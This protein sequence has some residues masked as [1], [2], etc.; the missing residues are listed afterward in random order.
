MQKGRPQESKCHVVI[1][2][3][4]SPLRRPQFSAANDLSVGIGSS[5]LEHLIFDRAVVCSSGQRLD[6]VKHENLAMDTDT[7]SQ[8]VDKKQYA[9][10]ALAFTLLRA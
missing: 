4:L 3:V 7:E 10:D 1:V 2:V 8:A 9:L 6:K 5:Y